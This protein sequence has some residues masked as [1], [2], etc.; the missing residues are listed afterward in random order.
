MDGSIMTET[1][2]ADHC[3]HQDGQVCRRQR[4][5]RAPCVRRPGRVAL[6]SLLLIVVVTG[7][8]WMWTR[9]QYFVGVEGDRVA[10]Y[11]GIDDQVG[12]VHFAS[13]AETSPVRVA[14]LPG[15]ARRQVESG[16]RA[17]DRAG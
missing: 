12:P 2:T 3:R 7:G 5:R 17:G 9:T 14:D 16:I 4:W 1:L 8:S 13:V 15:S 10:V 6:A 11:Q